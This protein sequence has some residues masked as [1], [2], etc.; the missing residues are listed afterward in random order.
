M[1]Y[2]DFE[3]FARAVFK[4]FNR[5][6]SSTKKLETWPLALTCGGSIAFTLG[7]DTYGFSVVPVTK[8]NEIYILIDNAPFKS[9]SE[10]DLDKI[11]KSVCKKLVEWRSAQ[12]LIFNSSKIN[13][14]NLDNGVGV[15]LITEKLFEPNVLE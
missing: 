3:K 15:F 1:R 10:K 11:F 14:E 2:D 5:P 7:S 4:T 6:P 8:M 9:Y 12:Q 13:L